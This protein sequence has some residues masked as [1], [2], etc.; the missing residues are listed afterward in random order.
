MEAHDERGGHET[1]KEMEYLSLTSYSAG[2]EY[3]KLQKL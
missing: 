1:N 3:K 2:N